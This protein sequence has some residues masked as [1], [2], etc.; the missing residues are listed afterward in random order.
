VDIVPRDR[1]VR[2][3]RHCKNEVSREQIALAT[4]GRPIRKTA[5]MMQSK[6]RGSHDSHPPVRNVVAVHGEALRRDRQGA[7]IGRPCRLIRRATL[8][9]QPL[10]ESGLAVAFSI[11]PPTIRRRQSRSGSLGARGCPRGS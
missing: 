2:V 9:G 1:I 6:M 7:L 8:A 4:L 10:P 3:A 11:K 5:A